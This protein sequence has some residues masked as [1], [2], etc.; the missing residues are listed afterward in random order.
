MA[1]FLLTCFRHLKIYP[2]SY[3]PLML[4]TLFLAM[5]KYYHMSLSPVL[6]KHPLTLLCFTMFFCL[7]F[8]PT[9]CSLLVFLHFVGSGHITPL[10]LAFAFFCFGIGD[11][12]VLPTYP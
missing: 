10:F 2:T 5:M 4:S 1:V 6:R 9:V 8:L 7:G 3:V 11:D 12:E